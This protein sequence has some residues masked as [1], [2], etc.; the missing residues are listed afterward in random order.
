MD[1][2]K[3]KRGPRQII[4]ENKCPSRRQSAIQ[5]ASSHKRYPGK[6]CVVSAVAWFERN[7]ENSFLTSSPKF[8]SLLLYAIDMAQE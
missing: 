7:V 3:H 6:T 5:G 4:D 8:Q 2:H 1:E